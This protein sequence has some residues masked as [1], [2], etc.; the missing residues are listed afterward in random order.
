MRIEPADLPEGATTWD[1]FQE[2][3][4]RVVNTTPEQLAEVEAAE[5]AERQARGLKKPGRP[6]G[7][8]PK[9]K[10]GEWVSEKK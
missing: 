3:A 10:N 7:T 5:E 9:R 8:R 1:R 6:P 4:R 2:I